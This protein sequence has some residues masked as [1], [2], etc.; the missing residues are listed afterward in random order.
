MSFIDLNKLSDTELVARYVVE[1]MGHGHFLSRDDQARIDRW[2]A[3]GLPVGDVLMVLNDVL[4]E[5]VEKAKVS[6]KRIFSLSSV[7]KTV[8]RR[9][10]DRRSLVGG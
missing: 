1:I 3:H 7:C 5:R 10:R 4:P 9:I 6:G 2:L 8:E